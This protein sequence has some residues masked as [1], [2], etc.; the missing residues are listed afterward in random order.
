LISNHEI[1]SLPPLSSDFFACGK[2]IHCSFHDQ[3]G[4]NQF[5]STSCQPEQP[6]QQHSQQHVLVLTQQL[7]AAA[8]YYQ[9][10]LLPQR[11]A[12]EGGR[13]RR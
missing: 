11:K 12:E 5:Q 3:P 6:A 10:A 7:A 8:S 4:S 1:A 9:P 2:T 13:W